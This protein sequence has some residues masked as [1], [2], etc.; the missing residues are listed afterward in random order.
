VKTLVIDFSRVLLFPVA[1]G[2]DS[3][4]ALHRELSADPHYQALD[5]FTL[6]LELLGYLKHLRSITPIYLF[7]DGKLHQLPEIVPYLEGIFKAVYSVES[8][9][10]SK[11]QPEAYKGLA[12][13]IGIDPSEIVFVDDK[14]TN[15]KAA[16]QAGAKSLLYTSNND[17]MR[18][19]DKF[20]QSDPPVAKND[21]HH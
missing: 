3:L 10:I 20:W 8:L 14:A 18:E 21:I 16:R 11:K 6:N 9:G 17:I 7:T 15:V 2:V 19:L 4:N 5:H 1:A 13:R 12:I